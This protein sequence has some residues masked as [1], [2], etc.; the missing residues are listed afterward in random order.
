[1]HDQRS[2][3]FSIRDKEKNSKILGK[4]NQ[5]KNSGENAAN[6]IRPE[7]PEKMNPPCKWIL[8]KL[9]QPGVPTKNI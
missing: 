3:F 4:D 2:S 7:I 9:P 8:M 5:S 6:R 1:M